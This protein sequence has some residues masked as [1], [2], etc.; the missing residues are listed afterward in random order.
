MRVEYYSIVERIEQAILN[1]EKMKLKIKYIELNMEEWMEFNE[2]LFS[3]FP[4]HR[5]VPHPDI[6]NAKYK[7]ID[8]KLEDEK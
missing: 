5:F 1:A 3:K 8:I 2:V 6:K 7:G 4:P